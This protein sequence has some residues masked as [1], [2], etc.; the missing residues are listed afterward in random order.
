MHGSP[1]RIHSALAGSLA[2]WRMAS[3]AQ[4]LTLWNHAGIRDT[5]QFLGGDQFTAV[6]GLR[7]R[8][9]QPGSGRAGDG[10]CS[11]GAPPHDGAPRRR[12]AGPL[13]EDDAVA[14]TVTVVVVVAVAVVIDHLGRNGRNG[15]DGP[16]GRC[17]RGIRVCSSM[18]HGTQSPR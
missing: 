10:R 13:T 9:G 2:G 14:V 6:D 16:D 4:V 1:S 3:R 15:L 7:A 18:S 11:R 17:R 5:D 12:S 8:T